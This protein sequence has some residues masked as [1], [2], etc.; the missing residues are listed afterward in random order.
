MNITTKIL[1]VICA[2]V[3]IFLGSYFGAMRVEKQDCYQLKK[4][5][6]DFSSF[7]LTKTDK[8]MC[9]HYN[10]SIVAPVK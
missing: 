3:I 2:L 7:Y 6:E 9:D 5:S 10:I 8:E 1:I 4:Q